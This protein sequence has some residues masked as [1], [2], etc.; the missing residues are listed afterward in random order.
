MVC[1]TKKLFTKLIL[2]IYRFCERI[3]SSG[4]IQYKKK[5]TSNKNI[6]F[7]N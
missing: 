5:Y 1:M 2:F 4:I 3:A 7:V 6:I